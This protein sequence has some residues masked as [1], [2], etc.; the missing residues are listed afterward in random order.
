MSAR[1]LLAILLLIAACNEH[2]A[3][4]TSSATGT[5]LSPTSVR[6]TMAALHQLGGV[7]PG[8]QLNPLTG[9][10]A[11]GRRSFE[12]LGCHSC[13]KVAGEKF[14]E[15]PPNG[16]GPELTGMG[17]HHPAAYFL[18]AII[19]PDA[20]VVE[21]PGWV[22]EQGRSTMPVYPDLTVTQLEDLV[23]YVSSLTTG[24]PHAGHIMPGAAKPDGSKATERPAA[25]TQAATAFL[26][27]GYEV[28]PGQVQA[29]EAWFRSEGARRF[30]AVEGLVA[31]DTFVD[32]TRAGPSLTTIWSFH[33]D[34]SLLAFVNANEAA[35][36][37]VAT[38]F[39]RFVT[40]HDHKVFHAPPLYRA[41]AL[42]ADIKT[43][44]DP[45][46]SVE[47]DQQTPSRTFR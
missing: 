42:S 23:A 20:V 21:G 39:D 33:D 46:P 14:S 40:P 22:T 19:N 31:I 17:A 18:E 32:E 24:D 38:D 1:W 12:D 36:I 30:G 16:P 3:S 8:W 11:A 47:S 25:P 43:V 7:P 41:A 15:S 4:P 29:F 44:R 35:T 34:A 2:T 5:R 26:S 10:V 37:A 6:I 13:H 28:L 27:Q 45:E 9:D